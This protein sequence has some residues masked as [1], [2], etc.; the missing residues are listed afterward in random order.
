MGRREESIVVDYKIKENKLALARELA[1]ESIVL[2]QNNNRVLPLKEEKRLPYSDA[3]SSTPSSAAAF[4][5][6]P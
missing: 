4:G 5:G 6:T 3:H 2:L 1:R